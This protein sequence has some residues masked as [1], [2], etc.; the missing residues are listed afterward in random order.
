MERKVHYETV[1]QALEQLRLQG[2]TVDFNLKENCDSV[3][4]NPDDYEIVDVYRYEGITDPGDEAA[5]YA[6]ESSSGVKG[7]LVTGYSSTSEIFTDDVLKNM[8]R[9]S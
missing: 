8:R 1:S 5:V 3:S 6:I 9:R 7:V 4:C 2:F